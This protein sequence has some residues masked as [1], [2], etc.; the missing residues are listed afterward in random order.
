M[1]RVEALARHFHEGI[2]ILDCGE[3]GLTH[4]RYDRDIDTVSQVAY[5]G[6]SVAMVKAH[7]SMAY[8]YAP[9]A[10]CGVYSTR[11]LQGGEDVVMPLASFAATVVPLGDT[12]FF[13]LRIAGPAGPIERVVAFGEWNWGEVPVSG[14]TKRGEFTLVRRDGRLVW[15]VRERD[16]LKASQPGHRLD[17]LEEKA[18]E[19]YFADFSSGSAAVRVAVLLS[20]L[21]HILLWGDVNAQNAGQ[22]FG[23][24]QCYNTCYTVLPRVKLIAREATLFNFLNFNRTQDMV[25][26]H[27]AAFNTEQAAYPGDFGAHVMYTDGRRLDCVAPGV[28]SLLVDGKVCHRHELTPFRA[29]MRRTQEVPETQPLKVVI[30]GDAAG[31]SAG[32]GAGSSAAPPVAP[33]ATPQRKEAALPRSNKSI[34]QEGKKRT[35]RVTVINEDLAA[36]H[37]ELRNKYGVGSMP[38]AFKVQK[39]LET[40]FVGLPVVNKLV[41]IPVPLDVDAAAIKAAILAKQAQVLGVPVADLAAGDW[42]VQRVTPGTLGASGSRYPGSWSLT[43]QKAK[44]RGLLYF[45]VATGVFTILL[46]RPMQQAAPLCPPPYIFLKFEAQQ[47][48]GDGEVKAVSV[49]IC[50]VDA[51]SEAEDGHVRLTD[52]ETAVLK[53][54]REAGGTLQ[55]QELMK[56][57]PA[58][59]KGNCGHLWRMRVEK[60]LIVSDGCGLWQLTP[61][62]RRVAEAL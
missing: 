34:A 31:S 24:A 30:P 19:G 28:R 41:F 39:D 11:I 9:N 14:G 62:G 47:V 53:A 57:V 29:E 18:A 5:T 46:T 27:G 15:A 17:E 1:K 48:G 7:V 36:K 59:A 25:F 22:G 13:T 8:D 21:T 20:P 40:D 56:R 10:A 2:H 6:L 26:G 4:F 12:D 43:G 51:R 16:Y 54:L 38:F 58:V 45:R 37:P 23:R 52:T 42:S 32:A 3:T 60:K 50:R 33:L 44:D 55:L 61:F 35:E 49:D